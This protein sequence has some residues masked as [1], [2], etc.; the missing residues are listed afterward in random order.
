[1][2]L[3]VAVSFTTRPANLYPEGQPAIIAFKRQAGRDLHTASLYV[4]RH[5]CQHEH[6][7]LVGI[8]CARF[9]LL[10]RGATFSKLTLVEYAH[11][12]MCMHASEAKQASSLMH[13]L[14]H[15]MP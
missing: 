7:S 4:P 14:R 2:V 15:M 8:P 1:M 9:R 3:C 13:Y 11:A 12:H 6:D 5:V 10:C